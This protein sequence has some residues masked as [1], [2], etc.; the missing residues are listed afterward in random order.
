MLESSKTHMMSYATKPSDDSLTDAPPEYPVT[1]W[2]GIGIVVGAIALVVIGVAG[3]VYKFF[4]NAANPKRASMIAQSLMDYTIP[5]E[6]EGVFGA[7]LGGAKVAVVSSASFPKDPSTLTAADMAKLS[8]VELFIARVP[9]DV[10]TSQDPALPPDSDEVS[11][12]AYD[13]FSSP[14]FSVSYRSG[15]DFRSI[16][17]RTEDRSFCGTVVPIRIQEGELRFTSELPPVR[18]VKY[19]ALAQLGT[20]KRQV[21]ITAIGPQATQQA[22]AV[23]QSLRCKA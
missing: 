23:F 6:A 15:E 22:E 8:G 17:D 3:L 21:T 12:E 20:G 7:N 11:K 14:D 5:G 19:D 4:D 9:L 16:T 1:V 10:E 18:A 2:E 13:I